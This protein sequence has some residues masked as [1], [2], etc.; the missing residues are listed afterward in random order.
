MK[1]YRDKKVIK[2]EEREVE[3]YEIDVKSLFKL[4]NNEYKS[5]EEIIIDNSN[6][7]K[8]DFENISAEAYLLIEKEFFELN[9]KHFSDEGERIDK[10]KS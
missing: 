6:L 9:K 10:K 5:N 8:E 3:L 7:K 2:F 4:A 1:F